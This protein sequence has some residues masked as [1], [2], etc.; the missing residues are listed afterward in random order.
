MP[1]GWRSGALV[2]SIKYFSYG[3]TR[4]GSAGT[5]K[6]FTGQRLDGTGLYN[7]NA[8]YYD[9]LLPRRAA[10]GDSGGAMKQPTEG[11]R[12]WFPAANEG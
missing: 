2:N 4:S 5:D 8:R 1:H 6:K 3:A 10:G 12:R 7:Y 11:R 9:A